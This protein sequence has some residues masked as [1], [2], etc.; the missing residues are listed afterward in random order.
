MP[1]ISIALYNCVE[2]PLPPVICCPNVFLPYG[3]DL[4]SSSLPPHLHT[5]SSLPASRFC[6]P[7][8]TAV[9]RL[10]HVMSC[11]HLIC[12][13]QRSSPLRCRSATGACSPAHARSAQPR[14][15]SREW[16]GAKWGLSRGHASARSNDEHTPSCFSGWCFILKPIKLFQKMGYILLFLV[17]SDEHDPQTL[18]LAACLHKALKRITHVCNSF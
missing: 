12:P 18:Q 14:T 10:Y 11:G 15:T 9:R 4:P 5:H 17:H 16:L 1:C 6:C 3:W 7:S 8:C 2:H 13:D